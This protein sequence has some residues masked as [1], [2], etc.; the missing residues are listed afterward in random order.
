MDDKVLQ[1]KPLVKVLS[2]GYEPLYDTG[3][4]DAVKDVYSGRLEV[5]ETHPTI[6][7]GTVGGYEPFPAVVRFRKGVFLGSI[8]LPSKTRKKKIVVVKAS[9]HILK[10]QHY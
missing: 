3:W 2:T 10:L 8:K 9:I 6:Q 4:Q 7:I 1:P 5:V